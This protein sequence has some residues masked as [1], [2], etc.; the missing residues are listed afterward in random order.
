MGMFHR[1]ILN[2]TSKKQVDHISG[3]TLDNRKSNLRVVEQKDNLKNK[4]KYSANK[5]GYPGV[6]WCDTLYTPKWVAFISIDRKRKHL[7][8]FDD[9][10]EAIK[11]RKKAESIFGEFKREN[12]T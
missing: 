4:G 2:E 7:G 5:S 12:I 6:Y 1:Y 8:Y 9:I 10:E 11:V 3:D